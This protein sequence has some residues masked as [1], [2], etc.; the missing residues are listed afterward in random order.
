MP[1]TL[2][3]KDIPDDLYKRLKR[4]AETRRWS[5]NGE[6]IVCLVMRRFTSLTPALSR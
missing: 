6:A 2:T 4:S 1:F 3:L 5:L